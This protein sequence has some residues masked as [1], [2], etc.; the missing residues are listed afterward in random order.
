MRVRAARDSFAFSF[1]PTGAHFALPLR[2]AT[3][4]ATFEPVV[5]T[6]FGYLFFGE[7]LD[8]PQLVGTARIIGALLLLRPRS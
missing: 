2:V 3:V 5:A 1:L 4:V 6:F 8:P 7:R